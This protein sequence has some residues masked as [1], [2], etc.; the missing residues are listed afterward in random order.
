LASDFKWIHLSQSGLA[1][2]SLLVLKS[3][4]ESQSG[5]AISME[6][7]HENSTAPEHME[8]DKQTLES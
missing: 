6:M 1:S 8:A 2:V 7:L 3:K 5:L 4:S